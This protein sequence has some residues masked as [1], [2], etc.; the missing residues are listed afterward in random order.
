MSR[1]ESVKLYRALTRELGEWIARAER[2]PVVS[3]LMSAKSMDSTPPAPPKKSTETDLA[4]VRSS[5]TAFLRDE[6]RRPDTERARDAAEVLA[7]LKSQRTYKYLLDKYNPTATLEDHERVR[8]TAR[9]V[10]LDLPK[11]IE[12]RLKE[13]E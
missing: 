6:F 11:D 8:L 1:Q 4:V 7:Y 5:L 3:A 9:R 10:G 2:E 13:D 12:R